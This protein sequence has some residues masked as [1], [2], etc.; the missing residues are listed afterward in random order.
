MKLSHDGQNCS[1]RAIRKK[2]KEH[3]QTCIDIMKEKKR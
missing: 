1:E 3:T 2:N